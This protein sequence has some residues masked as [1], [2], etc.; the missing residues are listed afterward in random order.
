MALSYILGH[1]LELAII[2]SL[3]TINAV[4]GFSHTRSSRRALDL[5]KGRLAVRARVLRDGEWTLRDARDLVPGDIIGIGLG[6]LVLADAKVLGGGE[7]VVDQSAVTAES[8]PVT[9]RKSRIVYSRSIAKHGEA[10]CVVVNTGTN[11]YSGR[12]VQLVRIAEPISHQEQIMC[13]VVKYTMYLSLVALAKVAVHSVLVHVDLLSLLNLTL[14]FLLGAVPVALPAV[15]A[16][17]LSLGA[18]EL[19]RK[20][21][22]VT[23][24]D[25]IEDAASM[26]V[27]L[28]DKTGTITQNRL[29]VSEPISKWIV[30]YP[31]LI[32]KS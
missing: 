29:S 9:V 11:T 7:L 13:A 18:I 30:A 32:S 5:L 22:L 24:L 26:Q 31:P 16:I 25:S 17:V 23:R 1:Y 3:L 21:A 27:L 28:L 14:T 12:T 2:F 8:L 6:D 19:A 15:F 4:I 10:R 20:G